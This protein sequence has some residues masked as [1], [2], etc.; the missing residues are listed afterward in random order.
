MSV[1]SRE[2]SS[3]ENSSLSTN[4]RSDKLIIYNPWNNNF[5]LPQINSTIN[6]Q[7]NQNSINTLKFRYKI[8]SNGKINLITLNKNINS[9]NGF[10]HISIS[11]KDGKGHINQ[12]SKTSK[13]SGKNMMNLAI[14]IL[15]KNGVHYC[16]LEDNSIFICQIY[17]NTIIKNIRMNYKII[18]LLKFGETYY[19]QFGFKPISKNNNENRDKTKFLSIMIDR[20]KE[21][22]WDDLNKFMNNTNTFITENR[23]YSIYYMNSYNKWKQFKDFFEIKY[24][25]PFSSFKEFNN[26]TCHL[27]VTWLDFYIHSANNIHLYSSFIDSSL[28]EKCKFNEFKNLYDILL[29]VKWINEDIFNINI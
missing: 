4:K 23:L 20:I 13:F 18:T 6:I 3:Y 8:N 14:K 25:R 15:Q 19:M 7:V 28:I 21:C 1:F 10:D 29:S 22:T 24:S 16:E 12:I 11:I 9:G 5:I 27:F 17:N 2:R 26:H